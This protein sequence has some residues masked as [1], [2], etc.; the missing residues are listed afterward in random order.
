MRSPKQQQQ[1]Q[2]QQQ[3]RQQRS[4]M[5]VGLALIYSSDLDSM[6]SPEPNDIMILQTFVNPVD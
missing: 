5:I 2:Q 1:Q 6:S 4:S 3:Q